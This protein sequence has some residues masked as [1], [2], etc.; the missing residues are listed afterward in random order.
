MCGIFI[1]VMDAYAKTKITGGFWIRAEVRGTDLKEPTYDSPIPIAR[2]DIFYNEE[3]GD[4]K[5]C[6]FNTDGTSAMNEDRGVKHR[7]Q[8]T[9]AY[10]QMAE[11]HE[12]KEFRAF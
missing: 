11:T 1:K 9:K 12:F 5:F 6:E 10:Q 4:F 2:I 7:D 8:K 3:T